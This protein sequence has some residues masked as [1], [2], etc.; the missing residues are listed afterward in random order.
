MT[1]PSNQIIPYY[2][3]KVLLSSL[4][5]TNKQWILHVDLKNI[6]QGLYMEHVVK[7]LATGKSKLPDTSIVSAVCSFL[8]IHMNF[9][10]MF[11][12]KIGFVFFFESNKSTYHT[13]IDEDYKRDR[14][15]GGFFG[16]DAKGKER[17]FYTV[18]SNLKILAKV[19]PVLPNV[20]CIHFDKMEADFVPY[21]LLSR[22]LV[23]FENT[24]HFVYSNDKDML[25]CLAVCDSCYIFRRS[26]KFKEMIGNG[27]ACS[28]YLSC[29]VPFPDS[30]FQFALAI[31]GDS[32]DN[33]DGVH[34]V[35]PV[36]LK[37]NLTKLIE[38][39]GGISN[40]IRNTCEGRTS[41]LDK[42]L[43]D[44]SMDFRTKRV[45]KFD[46][47]GGLSRN[48]RLVSFEVMSKVVDSEVRQFVV[49]QLAHKKAS[50]EEVNEALSRLSVDNCSLLS[51]LY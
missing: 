27:E 37:K 28:R 2:P 47:L 8:S 21:Y 26:G 44:G 29:E 51:A 14:Y 45:F 13:N 17:Y 43:F 39:G 16:L 41:L 20:T 48:M 25:Q 31:N 7:Q 5:D 30:Y 49:D 15:T 33:V 22:R 18:N 36:Y 12:K 46:E 4:S 24:T 34:G 9:A 19:L 6:M 1:I 40:I 42:S 10:R 32:A 23:P 38:A 3:N 50:F 35:G 11:N